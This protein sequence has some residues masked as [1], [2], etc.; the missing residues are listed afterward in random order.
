MRP[1]PAPRKL[2]RPLKMTF[3]PHHCTGISFH[4]LCFGSILLYIEALTDLNCSPKCKELE[5]GS[6]ID[7][8]DCRLREHQERWHERLN[9]TAFD[10]P[11]F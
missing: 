1:Y 9:F 3:G 5:N 7:L 10:E 4:L 11:L 8:C 6:K 2:L